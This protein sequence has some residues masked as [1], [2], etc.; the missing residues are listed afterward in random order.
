MSS[1]LFKKIFRLATGSVRIVRVRRR[2]VG[3]L[4]GGGARTYRAHK[5][6]ARTLVHRK[7]AELNQHYQLSWGKVAIRNQRSRWGSCS[8]KGNLNF[9]YRIVFLP[10]HLQDYIIVHE[11]CHLAVFDHSATFW[12]RVAE[13]IPNHALRRKELTML[14]RKGLNAHSKDMPGPIV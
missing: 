8:K 7:L 11:L 6:V 10:T 14:V 12:A 3:A 2:R 13:T 9:N 1:T 5:E 4:S